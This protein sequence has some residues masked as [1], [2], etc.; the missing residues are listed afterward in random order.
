VSAPV[1]LHAEDLERLAER[2]AELV[3]ERM[4][5]TPATAG[6][7]ELVDAA[8]IARRTGLTAAT[9]RARADEFGAVRIGDGP[10]PRL[11]FDPERVDE[12]PTAGSTDK[13]SPEPEVPAQ[14][15]IRRRR[16]A[17]RSGAGPEL[18]PIKGT[19]AL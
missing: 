12:A 6:S 7:V 19:R 17:A 3:L 13:R 16:R 18:L 5:D 9:V 14:P 1:R 11:R 4:G 8:E 15:T 2:V 10:R